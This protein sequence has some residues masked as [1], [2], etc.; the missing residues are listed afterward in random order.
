MNKPTDEELIEEI[1]RRFEFNQNALNDMR[2]MTRKLESMNEKLQES[3]ALKS[4]FLSNIRNEINNPLSAIM[5]LAAQFLGGSCDPEVC[6]KTIGM[7]YA[8]AFN[9]DY[10]LQNVFMAA[11]LEA[12]EAEP[13][14]A[15]VEIDSLLD[16]CLDK[17]AYRIRDKDLVV[18]K[19]MP[20]DLIFPTDAQKFEMILLN[21]LANAAEFTGQKGEVSVEI[22]ENKPG[23]TVVV[24]DN[25]PGITP[26]D[27]EVVF[28]RFR[29]LEAGTTKGHRG[30][31]LGLSICWSLVE[32]LDGTIDLDS[33]PGHGSRFVVTLPRPDVK[34]VMHATEGNFFLFDT[35]DDEVETF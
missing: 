16:G 29:Q 3:E 27:Q 4:Q 13:A 17:L 8:E 7:I 35:T 25:G 19:Y 10:Q 1:R 23:L 22:E 34:T 30:H 9:L 12:G 24:S 6:Q 31:G 33:Q 14:I 5:G 32:L 28:D 20:E 26:T 11:E 2:A 15:M 18:T 21:L